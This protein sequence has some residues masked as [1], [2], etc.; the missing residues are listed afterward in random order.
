MHGMVIRRNTARHLSRKSKRCRAAL[1]S[2]P[3]EGHTRVVPARRF[4]VPFPSVRPAQFGVQ[5]EV[6]VGLA[7][8]WAFQGLVGTRGVTYTGWGLAYSEARDCA[9]SAPPGT[10]EVSSPLGTTRY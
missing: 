8:G 10:V 4:L 1:R 7:A 3:G 6:S 2:D 9:G 5:I